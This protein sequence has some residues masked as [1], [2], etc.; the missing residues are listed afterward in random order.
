M[1]VV[2]QPIPTKHATNNESACPTFLVRTLLLQATAYAMTSRGAAT[3]IITK[4][5][6]PSRETTG[7]RL[8]GRTAARWR[9]QRRWQ[10]TS[11]SAPRSTSSGAHLVAP[12][13]VEVSPTISI[14]STWFRLDAKHNRLCGQQC[15]GLVH[16]VRITNLASHQGAPLTFQS[17]TILST[18]TAPHC[19]APGGRSMKALLLAFTIAASLSLGL[20][21]HAQSPNTVTAT[22]KD[23]TAYSGATRRGACRGHGGVEK[24]TPAAAAP[25][26]AAVPPSSAPARTTPA[27]APRSAGGGAGQVWVN[28]ASKVYHCPGDRYYGKT[29]AGAYMTEAAAKAQGDR[30]D[31]GKS[32]S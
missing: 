8:I 20:P 25:S 30:P 4:P 18:I 27:P 5:D 23:G 6:N 28:T 1:A 24:F 19:A 32:C 13:V 26:S 14:R 31:H 21:A 12:V 3:D 7:H 17:R 9:K 10:A 16:P 11:A 22:C 29:K 15:I 2:R